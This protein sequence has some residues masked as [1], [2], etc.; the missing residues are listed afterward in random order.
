LATSEINSF[1]NF[2]YRFRELLLLNLVLRLLEG[3]VTA[4]TSKS[5][6]VSIGHRGRSLHWAAP[7]HSNR[8]GDGIVAKFGNYE[9][10]GGAIRGCAR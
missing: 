2:G 6:I 1:E 4:V 9:A 7:R 10:D 5:V 8:E 3:P